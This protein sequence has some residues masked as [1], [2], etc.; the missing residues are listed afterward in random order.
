MSTGLHNSVIKSQSTPNDVPTSSDDVISGAVTDVASV[1]DA[2]GTAE[3][4]G[5]QLVETASCSGVP[6]SGASST[7]T[8]ISTGYQL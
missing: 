8:N 1:D 7:Y 2:A 6:A 5:A 3:H 4:G